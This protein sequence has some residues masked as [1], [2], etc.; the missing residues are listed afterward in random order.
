[1]SNFE[2]YVCMQTN[3]K[4]YKN[5][6]KFRPVGILWHSTGANNPNIKRYVQPT[7]GSVNYAKDISKFGKNT[8]RNDWNHLQVSAGVNAFIGK[9]A[10]GSVGTVQCLP[11]DYAPWG[12]GS[13]SRGS[14]NKEKMADN[15]YIGWIQ[16]EICEDNLSNADY[17]NK[18]FNEAVQLTAYL[19]KKYKIDPDGYVTIKGVKIPTI[20]CHNDASKLGFAT[21]HADINHWFPKLIGK[22]MNNVRQE[23]KALIGG[24]SAPS[25]PSTPAP[26][27]KPATPSV[28]PS[29]PILRVGS[30]GDAVRSLQTKLKA[31]INPNLVIDGDFGNNTKNAVINFQKKYGLTPDGIYGPKSAAKM[32]EVYGSFNQAPAGYKVKITAS[33]LNVRRGPGSSYGVV[34]VLRR[35]EVYTIIKEQNGWGQLKSGQG[36][37]SLKFTQK[38]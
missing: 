21:N 33:A 14:C 30:K 12:C 29:E 23:V 17:A 32:K 36:W 5:T 20:T 35:G 15:S 16:F 31:I 25:A 13:G 10:D 6:V 1:M 8:N 37:I 3:S 9:Y 26:A 24:G 28:T 34:N 11:W 4:C 18:V 2:P 38:V 19:C 22:N 7:D 27:P